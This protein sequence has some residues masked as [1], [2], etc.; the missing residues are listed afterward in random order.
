M[1]LALAVTALPALGWPLLS[2]LSAGSPVGLLA[3]AAVA[4][5]AA[6]LLAAH[7]RPRVLPAVL[8]GLLL[9]S[10]PAMALLWRELFLLLPLATAVIGGWAIALALW[11]RAGRLDGAT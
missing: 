11:L 4:V 5:A 9:V 8:G 2:L 3:P 10:V 1:W 6:P 7:H